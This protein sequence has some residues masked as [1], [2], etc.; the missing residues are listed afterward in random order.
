M[1]ARIS[2]SIIVARVRKEKGAVLEEQRCAWLD[3]DED[4]QPQGEGSKCTRII[5]HASVAI[6]VPKTAGYLTPC[7][8]GWWPTHSSRVWSWNIAKANTLSS[9]AYTIQSWAMPIVAYT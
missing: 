5:R 3:D 4:I 2:S 7:A 9:F 6:N 1:T 8:S